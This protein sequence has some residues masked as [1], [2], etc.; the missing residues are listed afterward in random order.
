MFFSAGGSINGTEMAVARSSD[1]G[2][3]LDATF[4]AP[5]TGNG[6]FNDKPMITVDTGRSAHHNR[7]YVAWDNATGNSSSEKNGN[8]VVLSYSDDGGVTF[9]APVSVSGNF[10]GKTGGI[11]ADPYVTSDGT[12]HVAWQD[13]A[14][15]VIADASSTDGGNTFSA[16]HTIATVGGVAFDCRAQNT[17]GALVYPACGSFGTTL[18]CSYTDDT[19]AGDERLRREVDRRRRHLALGEADPGAG[20]QFNQWLAVDPARRLGQ[21]RVLRHRHVKVR[22]STL[23]TLARS[24]E[25]RLSPSRHG[26]R[27]RTD[28]RDD[29]EPASTSATSTAITKGSPR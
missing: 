17:R 8:N 16:P 13:Y 12:L 14:H 24:I 4:F 6:Q 5:Q 19:V 10:I 11:G 18:F 15:G 27:E 21:R 23:S 26:G 1:G 29:C 28:R 2:L 7:I 20:D 9:S 25:R 22:P 3:D